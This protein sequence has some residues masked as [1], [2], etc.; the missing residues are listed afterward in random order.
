M[1]KG[2]KWCEMKMWEE[3]KWREKNQKVEK[4]S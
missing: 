3:R 1:E 2:R 4:E